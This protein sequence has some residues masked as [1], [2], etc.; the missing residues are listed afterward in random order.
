M[1]K[2]FTAEDAKGYAEVA[3]AAHPARSPKNHNE[4]VRR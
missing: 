3:M 4:T 2:A 1:T